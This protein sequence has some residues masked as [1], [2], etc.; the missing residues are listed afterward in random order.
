MPTWNGIQKEI[1]ESGIQHAQLASSSVD[2]VRR[3]YLKQLHTHT[4][5]NII[6]YYSG[7]QSKPGIMQS[8]IN[9]EDKN[10][11]MSAIHGLDR[12]KGLDLILHTPG[13]SFA[14]T[15]SI[16]DYLRRMF[17][18]DIRAIVPQSAF[19]GGTIIA[20]SCKSI[21]MGKESNLGPVDPQLAGVPAYG[22]IE[23]FKRAYKEIKADPAKI[24]IWQPIIQQYRP[25]FL[26]QCENSI[27]WSKQFLK[28]QLE[29]VM[30]Y[31][32]K[33]KST[34][35]SKIVRNLT[36]YSKGHDRHIH[37]DECK[38]MGLKI[39]ELETDQK[40][41]DLVLT[42]HHCYMHVFMNLPAYKITENQKGV[43]IIK[44]IKTN[45]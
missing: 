29:E 41:Q 18:R 30:F 37:I 5:R 13:G 45:N 40:L 20:C 1:N 17:G 2:I 15:Q 4:G 35:I 10:G 25:T 34:S 24:S 22:V 11:F 6:A 28:E 32:S 44:N 16:V 12:S 9:D 21:V 14:A 42:V 33:N 19:S 26:T 38:D 27:K 3:K 39:E 8:S 31:R 36:D 7:F 43:A 23:E